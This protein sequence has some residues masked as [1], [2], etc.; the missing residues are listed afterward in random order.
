MDGNHPIYFFNNA[1][2]LVDL[3]L[4]E[5]TYGLE[6]INIS[7]QVDAFTRFAGLIALSIGDVHLQGRLSSVSII[8]RHQQ[9]CLLCLKMPAQEAEQLTGQ[10]CVIVMF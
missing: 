6:A 1:E 2:A 3:Y 5:I 9:I 4:S 8:S 7:S 10:A